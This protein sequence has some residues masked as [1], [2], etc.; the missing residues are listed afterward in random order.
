MSLATE[1]IKE[2]AKELGRIRQRGVRRVNVASHNQR[3]TEAPVLDSIADLYASLKDLDGVDRPQRFRELLWDALKKYAT[4]NGMTDSAAFVRDLFF[5]PDAP[6]APVVP[7]ELLS[8]LVKRLGYSHKRAGFDHRRRQEFAEFSWFLVEFVCS[9]VDAQNERIK[10]ERGKEE[11]EKERAQT[12]EEKKRV[13]ATTKVPAEPRK[14]AKKKRPGLTPEQRKRQ[15]AREKFLRQQLRR[16]EQRRKLRVRN[17]IIAAVLAL[18][19]GVSI[20]LYLS[21]TFKQ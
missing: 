11:A 14:G 5:L 20:A 17:S 7:G 16:D 13:V 6:D 15:L 8:D 10:A 4:K 19:L 1:D 21:G 2:L 9:E 3:P 18:W 12:K